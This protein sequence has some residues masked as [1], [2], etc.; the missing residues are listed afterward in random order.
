MPG[1]DRT[2][3]MGMGP[4]TGRGMGFCAGNAGPGFMNPG[5]WGM[6]GRGR[7]WRH[8]FHATGLTGWQRQAMGWQASG[9][10]MP[11]PDAAAPDAQQELQVL[12]QQAR[13][14]A[15]ALE[16]LQTRIEQLQGHKPTE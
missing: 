11:M 15:T 14:M 12:Q 10:A 16:N 4:R 2:G 5:G 1:G 13:A 7:G 9:G 3:P 6:R 8:A